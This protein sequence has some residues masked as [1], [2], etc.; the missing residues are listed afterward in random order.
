MTSDKKLMN[1]AVRTPAETIEVDMNTDQV[2]CNGGI[3]PLGHPWAPFCKK[4][5]QFLLI[6]LDF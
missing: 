2:V 3:G 6:L 5:I 4:L 1:K